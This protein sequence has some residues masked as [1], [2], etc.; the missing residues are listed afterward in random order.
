MRWAYLIGWEWFAQLE[1]K[2]VEAVADP[3]Y[4]PANT[5]P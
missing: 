3:N 2:P 4:R 5:K 1:L